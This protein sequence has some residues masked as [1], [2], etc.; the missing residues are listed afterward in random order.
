MGRFVLHYLI[1]RQHLIY[2]PVYAAIASVLSAKYGD[3]HEW[4]RQASGRND[5]LATSPSAPTFVRNF[6]LRCHFMSF[7]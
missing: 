4:P 6:T 5:K 2:Q 7:S 1:K 3:T